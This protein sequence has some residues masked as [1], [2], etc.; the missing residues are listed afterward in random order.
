MKNRLTPPIKKQSNPISL[1]KQV[2]NDLRIAILTGK[3]PSGARL[4]ES[5]LASEMGV[6]RTPI[7]EALHQ[8]DMEE[9]VYSIPRV[10]Y[11]VSDMSEYDIEDLF[12]TR[13]AIEQVV[14]RLALEKITPEDLKKIENNLNK[15]ENFIKKGLT[16]KTVSLDMEFHEIICRACRSKRLY[17][18]SQLLREHMHKFRIA[19]L[20]LPEIAKRA[21][22]GHIDIFRALKSKDRK[23]LDHAILSHMEEIKN[24]VLDYMRQ[25]REKSF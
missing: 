10:G 21:H 3:I 13:A 7:R 11:L 25:L 17:Q 19:S 12:A 1:R 5:V 24:I 4:V 2:Y 14:A 8:L 16:T 23:R 20:H 18:I 15:A 22:E 9:L 6:S